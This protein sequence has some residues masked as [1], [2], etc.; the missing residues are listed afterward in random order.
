M[1][2]QDNSTAVVENTQAPA[3]STPAEVTIKVQQVPAEAP[4]EAS[5]EEPVN[6]EALIP[7]DSYQT[8]P[9]FYAISD[10]FNIPPEEYSIAKDYLSEITDYLIRETESNDP[11]VLLEKIREIEDKVQ[12]PSWGEKRYWNIRKYVRLAVKKNSIEKA[13]NAFTKGGSHG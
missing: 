13:M 3:Q 2:A 5:K 12:P 6:V 11:S 7:K 4:S 1:P 10:Y 9:L 8:D